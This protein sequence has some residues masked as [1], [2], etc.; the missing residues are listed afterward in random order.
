MYSYGAYYQVRDICQ[1][2]I[3]QSTIPA[4]DRY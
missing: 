2:T 3:L 4:R 1:E